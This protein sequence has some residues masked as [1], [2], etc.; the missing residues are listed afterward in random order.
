MLEVSNVVVPLDGAL[1]D[2]E[3]LLRKAVALK[4]GVPETVIDQVNVLKRSVDARKK[5]DVHFVMTVSVAL[6]NDTEEST[7]L[8]AA[9]VDESRRGERYNFKGVI[10][11]TYNRVTDIKASMVEFGLQTAYLPE[12]VLPQTFKRPVVVGT[13]PA[14]LFAALY[15]ARMGMRPVVLELGACMEERVAAV[16]RFEKTGQFSPLTNI[17]FGEGGAGTFSDGK[18]T[19][20]TK[21]P[22]TKTVLKWFVEAGAPEEILI[23]AKPHIGTDKLRDVVRNMRQEIIGLGGEVRFNTQLVD[24]IFEDNALTGVV[25]ENTQTGQRETIDTTTAI[26]ATG[27]SARDTFAMMQ[28]KGLFMERKPF[29]VGVRIEHPQSLIN[30]AQYGDF[31]SHPALGAADYKLSAHLNNG[32]GVYTFCMCPGGQVVAATSEEGAVCVNGM[33]LHARDGEN[34]N[35]AV[36]VSVDPS[37]FP[38]DDPLAGVEFQRQLEKA[39]YD[40]AQKNGGAPYAAPAQRVGDFLRGAKKK[41]AGKQVNCPKVTPSYARG[42]AW[43]DLHECLPEFVSESLEQALPQFDRRIKGFASDNA[44][45]TAVETRSSSPVRV[46]RDSETLQATFSQGASATGVYPC[47]EGAGYAGGIMSAAVDGIRVAKV[48][49]QTLTPLDLSILAENTIPTMGEMRAAFSLPSRLAAEDNAPKSTYKDPQGNVFSYRMTS[50]DTV[51]IVACENASDTVVCPSFIEG[52][53][54]DELGPKVFTGTKNLSR[55]T[56]SAGATRNSLSV[57]AAMTEFEYLALP[58]ALLSLDTSLLT[59]IRE[60]DTLCLPSMAKKIPLGLFRGRE[61]KHLRVGCNA[62]EVAVGA[63]EGSTLEDVWIDPRNPWLETDGKGIYRKSDN[64]LLVLAVSCS[65]YQVKDG[66]TRVCRKAF[67]NIAQL[68][69]V[70]LPSTVEVL[71]TFCFFNAGLESFC[72]PS[73]LKTIQAKAFYQ[74]SHLADIQLN[75]GLTCIGSEA[76]LRTAITHLVIPR[77]MRQ[78]DARFCGIPSEVDGQ[79]VPRITVPEDSE[80]LFMDEKQG[81]Y[82]WEGEDLFFVT[83]LNGSATTYE[84]DPRTKTIGPEAFVQL[85]NLTL[86]ELPERLEFICKRAF[87]GC[88]SL[89]CV[90][91]SLAL[92]AIGEDAFVGTSLQRLFLPRTTEFLAS[93]SLLTNELNGFTN[94]HLIPEVVVEPDSPLLFYE[95]DVLCGRLGGGGV[96]AIA[97]YG[98]SKNVSVP[99]FCTDVRSFFLANAARVF[100]VETHDGVTFYEPG[101]FHATALPQQIVVRLIENPIDGHDH[102]VLRY[103]SNSTGNNSLRRSFQPLS[104]SLAEGLSVGHIPADVKEELFVDGEAHDEVAP[105]FRGWDLEGA[106]ERSDDSMY[107]TPSVFGIGAHSLDRLAN[108][109]LLAE[110][111]RNRFTDIVSHRLADLVEVFAKNN[112]KLGFEQLFDLGFITKNN[113][114][115]VIDLASEANNTDLVS[116]LFDLRRRKFGYDV[117][118]EFDL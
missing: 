82:R 40:L 80:L 99:D 29:S 106:V 24:F 91:G 58:D 26:V 85:T 35:S 98:S 22:L 14:G 115:A 75:E 76:F 21:N 47:G 5:S 23:D 100:S 109:V 79:L 93:T 105:E 53:L 41:G 114:V 6:R 51:R 33:S 71:E 52:K 48:V 77:T 4:L 116:F 27:H 54:V 118:S 83:L 32:R 107:W 62:K 1:P 96:A 56:M 65:A 43:S 64:A 39:A 87:A 17:Q 36:L 44:V 68:K 55:L 18:L 19:T 78:L 28:E 110:K 30:T 42:V 95:G 31:A 63:F 101:C 103:P 7:V 34:A 12:T 13:G 60:I 25:T 94:P 102:L 72:A 113:V 2:G 67:A 10:L 8:S 11:P 3:P 69:Q 16:E 46:V 15:L 70:E 88:K 50:R 92:R 49:A 37:D 86:V 59:D 90:E 61:I 38:G 97:Y 74:C 104:L 112:Y 66:C 45:M 20:N 108:P 9:N 81:L 73:G 117:M 57:L 111:S 84:L 89:G